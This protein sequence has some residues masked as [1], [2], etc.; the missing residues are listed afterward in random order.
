MSAPRVTIITPTTRDR[1]WPVLNRA[2]GSVDGQTFG[3]YEHIICTDGQIDPDVLE[4]L[5]LP[6]Q[7]GRHYRYTGE[8]QGHY[9]AG[10]RQYLLDQEECRGEYLCFLDD[11]NVLLPDYLEKMVGALDQNPDCGFAIG[12]IL[13]FGPLDRDLWPGSGPWLMPGTPKLKSID[14]LQVVVRTEAMKE[15]GGWRLSGYKSDG[16][17]YEELGRS[18]EHCRV[19]DLVGIHF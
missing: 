3:G 14:T 15:I 8:P 16:L 9:G 12:K 1:P 13:H 5:T 11:D 10:V 18:Y 4:K 7:P 19:D 6:R 17:T 2:I